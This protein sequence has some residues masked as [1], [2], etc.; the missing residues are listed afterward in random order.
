MEINRNYYSYGLDPGKDNIYTWSRNIPRGILQDLYGKE[1]I[2]PN[3][4]HFY[5]QYLLSGFR[6]VP[7]E[8]TDGVRF[9]EE[10]N[11]YMESFLPIS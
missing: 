3:F 7:K 2:V 6:L 5:Q 4:S 11:V 9:I 10:R 1:A 8:L